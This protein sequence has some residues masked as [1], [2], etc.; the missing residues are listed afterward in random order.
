MAERHLT[1]NPFLG[2]PHF[3]PDRPDAAH[4]KPDLEEPLEEQLVHP[5]PRS[6]HRLRA[7]KQRD[8][9][10]TPEFNRSYGSDKVEESWRYLVDNFATGTVLTVAG[11]NV[12]KAVTL[13]NATNWLLVR[14][15]GAVQLY[16]CIRKFSIAPQGAAT[17][18]GNV[19]CQFQDA[20]SGQTIPLG[21]VV[22]NGQ[23]I[24]DGAAQ[25]P[26]P[27]TDPGNAAIGTLNFLLSAGGTPLTYN[28]QLGVSAVYVIPCL[29]GYTA[30]SIHE[31]LHEPVAAHR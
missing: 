28:W 19:D 5:A 21:N 4:L 10:L 1:P 30:E 11:A 13:T 16:L 7:Y 24:F 27:V 9:V 15:P 8:K 25:I 6:D 2:H 18:T 14:W 23:I 20:V 12:A 26:S 22:T 3:T 29:E 17:L 31:V